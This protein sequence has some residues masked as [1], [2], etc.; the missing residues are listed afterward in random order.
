MTWVKP[1]EIP[2]NSI[3]LKYVLPSG[4]EV[5]LPLLA[6]QGARRLAIWHSPGSQDWRGSHT[7][8]FS[9]R[10]SPTSIIVSEEVQD[11]K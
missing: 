9:Q 2:L 8:K 11:E 3:D 10:L 7:N 4:E 5:R 6:M 1:R